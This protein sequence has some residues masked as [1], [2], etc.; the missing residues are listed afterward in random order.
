M[1]LQVLLL[2]SQIEAKC[3]LGC[4]DLIKLNSYVPA[5]LRRSKLNPF[6]FVQSTK[7]QKGLLVLLLQKNLRSELGEIKKIDTLKPAIYR[8]SCNGSLIDD[9]VSLDVKKDCRIMCVLQITELFL[10]RTVDLSDLIFPF[11][12]ELIQLVQLRNNMLASLA[13]RMIKVK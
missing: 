6:C 5:Q 4:L 9:L 3:L 13:L 7:Y 12:C 2:I 11:G 8:F 10:L 1:Q